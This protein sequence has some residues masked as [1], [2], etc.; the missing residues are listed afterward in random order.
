MLMV[1]DSMAPSRRARGFLAWGSVAIFKAVI[2][3]M[4]QRYGNLF[5]KID[6]SLARLEG[7]RVCEYRAGFLTSYA[8][9]GRAD[10]REWVDGFWNAI[11]HAPP[12][13]WNALADDE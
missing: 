12:A 8:K 6:R 4:T 7:E 11:K 9:P 13:L 10:N 3:P 5:Q 2:G 1:A